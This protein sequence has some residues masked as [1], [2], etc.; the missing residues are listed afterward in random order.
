M[1]TRKGDTISAGHFKPINSRRYVNDC[2]EYV[3]HLTKTGEVP[4]DR[5]GAGWEKGRK[6]PLLTASIQKPCG[7]T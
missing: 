5:R 6:I 7:D 2:H 4:L 1:E 3:F